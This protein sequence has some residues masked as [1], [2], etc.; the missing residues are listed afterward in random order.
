MGR[1]LKEWRSE[2]DLLVAVKTPEKGTSSQSN[3]CWHQ[4]S[5]SL[6]FLYLSRIY[7]CSAQDASSQSR[8]FPHLMISVP[9]CFFS[10]KYRNSCSTFPIGYP[11]RNHKYCKITLDLLSFWGHKEPVTQKLRKGRE[12][13]AWMHLSSQSMKSSW[14]TVFM[15][16][17]FCLW[18]RLPPSGMADT[19][20]LQLLAQVTAHL[21]KYQQPGHCRKTLISWLQS[22]SWVITQDRE[23][24]RHCP[25]QHHIGRLCHEGY[26]RLQDVVMKAWCQELPMLVPFGPMQDQQAIPF[27]NTSS[28]KAEWF[29]QT[30]HKQIY[31]NR[32]FPEVVV[33][34]RC[35]QF[36]FVQV[37]MSEL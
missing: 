5:P 16:I 11:K 30:Q 7:D 8:L 22:E 33:T 12:T 24:Y 2:E 35:K 37:A 9:L 17:E 21:C 28:E 15:W 20:G 29:L 18:Y 23:R 31:H 36:S 3:V 32:S 34:S 6:F 4:A 1:V 25:Y 26:I 19:V 27:G 10:I 13:G 14:G